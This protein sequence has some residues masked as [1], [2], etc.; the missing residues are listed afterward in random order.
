MSS[1]QAARA[2]SCS[3]SFLERPSP[4][5]QQRPAQE[6]LGHVGPVVVGPRPHHHVAG[7]PLAV[8]HRLLLQPA[9]VV[10]VVGLLAGP[11][12]GL[13]QL[14]QHQLAARPPSRRRGRPP[15][16]RPRRRRPGWRPWSGRL[17]PPRPGP[18]GGPHRPRAGRPPGPARGRSP[19]RSGPWPACPRRSRGSARRCSR[20]RRG[21][22][23]RRRGT[24]GARWRARRPPARRTS[25]G[26]RGRAE[27][28]SGRRRSGQV[29][30]PVRPH[31]QRRRQPASSLA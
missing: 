15:R 30:R 28:G 23:R 19:R 10:E 9:L 12:D 18:A 1:S 25:C 6:H 16:G 29:A 13:A 17:T 24:R 31:P 22:G 14:A 2:A 5:P 4:A 27:G 21:P 11:L 8:A 3:A 20:P 7:R 26:G